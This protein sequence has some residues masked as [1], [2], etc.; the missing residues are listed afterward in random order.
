MWK[1]NPNNYMQLP[2]H[3]RAADT[4]GDGLLNKDEFRAML[5]QV[6][7]SMSET[8]V[9]AIFAKADVDVSLTA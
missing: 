5:A 9:Q 7:R 4:D 3:I 6:G 1:G 8:E 2:A